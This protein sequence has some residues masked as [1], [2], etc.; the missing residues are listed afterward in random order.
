[1]FVSSAA[2][3]VGSV[4]YQIAKIKGCPVVGSCGSDEKVNGY[5]MN[6]N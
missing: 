2:G 3:G 1:V 4:A 5:L 6:L